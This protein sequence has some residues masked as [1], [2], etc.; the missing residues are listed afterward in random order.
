MCWSSDISGHF[1]YL[2]YT[3]CNLFGINRE[4]LGNVYR[5]HANVLVIPAIPRLAV[6]VPIYPKKFINLKWICSSLVLHTQLLVFS[7]DTPDTPVCTHLKF[8]TLCTVHTAH[9]LLALNCAVSTYYQLEKWKAENR[10]STHRYIYTRHTSRQA[11]AL[12]HRCTDRLVYN[13][14]MFCYP[15][16]LFIRIVC[17]PFSVRMWRAWTYTAAND[18]NHFSMKWFHSLCNALCFPLLLVY[19]L[20]IRNNVC[21]SVF[22]LSQCVCRVSELWDA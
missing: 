1:A 10:H 15:F 20:C 21:I 2:K 16:H 12:Y 19:P 13:K 4:V 9:V 17:P 18:A 7:L 5:M 11:K 22:L 6:A 8:Y 14:R 3:S